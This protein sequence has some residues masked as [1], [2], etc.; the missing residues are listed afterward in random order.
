MHDRT[1]I[2]PEAPVSHFSVLLSVK[3]A[4]LPAAVL[5][6]ELFENDVSIFKS[7]GA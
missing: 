7:N 5:E 6:L 1:F 3:A 2:H 4:E